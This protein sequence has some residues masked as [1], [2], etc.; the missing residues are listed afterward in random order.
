VAAD[1]RPALTADYFGGVVVLFFLVFF[2]VVFFPVEFLD[3]GVFAW[4]C[5]VG[6]PESGAGFGAVCASASELVRKSAPIAS[7][8]SL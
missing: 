4:P 2:R 7:V 3:L 5:V 8:A 6:L 1:E